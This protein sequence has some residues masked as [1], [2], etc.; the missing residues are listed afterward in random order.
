MCSLT[1]YIFLFILFNKSYVFVDL[2]FNLIL[3]N[4]FIKHNQVN[5]SYYNIKYLDLYLSLSFS[6]V[7]SLR[8]NY[9]PKM[10]LSE[11]LFSV[12]FF[13]TKLDFFSYIFFSYSRKKKFHR[14]E[15]TSLTSSFFITFFSISILGWHLIL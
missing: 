12:F 11:C 8:K 4:R 1:W 7:F 13:S 15:L 9:E 2:Y 14:K 6:N 3:I 10:G 5:Y